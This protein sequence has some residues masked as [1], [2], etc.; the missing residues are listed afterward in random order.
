MSDRS[1]VACKIEL[2]MTC[3]LYDVYGV[4]VYIFISRHFAEILEI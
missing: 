3:V 4:S 2:H 1:A